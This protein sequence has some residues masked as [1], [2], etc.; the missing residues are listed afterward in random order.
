MI[1]RVLAYASARRRRPRF[2]ADMERRGLSFSPDVYAPPLRWPARS[3][4]TL[5]ALIFFLAAWTWTSG[6]PMGSLP[7]APSIAA[8]PPVVL[9][10]PDA[11]QGL[12]DSERLGALG[13]DIDRLKRAA[14]ARASAD[15]A[16]RRELETRV[17]ALERELADA[18]NER[19]RLQAQ[20]ADATQA[21]DATGRELSQARQQHASDAMLLALQDSRLAALSTK[22]RDADE[23][24]AREDQLLT[25]NRDIRDLMG[26]RS[27]HVIDVFDVDGRGKTRRAFGR[28]F[29]TE[30]KSLI[31]YA[32][33]L[34]TAAARPASFQAW[35]QREGAAATAFSL[36]LLYV[37]DQTQN[38]WALKFEDARVLDQIDAVFVTVEP[39]G[40]SRSPRGRKLLYAYL[41]QKPNHP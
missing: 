31:F 30:G 38:R 23:R 4:K 27:L 9:A 32:F 33:D 21:L 24:L 26:A 29:Y 41:R 20:V 39:P 28:A 15:T 12:T 14:A 19:R 5:A 17:A 37:D 35:G 1:D 10:P 3:L 25:A 7:A 22:I 40:G 18:G 13:A 8:V 6:I 2:L 11:G 16:L 36:G 34:A